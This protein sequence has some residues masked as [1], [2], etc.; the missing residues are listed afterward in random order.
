VSAT[1]VSKREFVDTGLTVAGLRGADF[2]SGDKAG[3]RIAGA[4]AASADGPGVTYVYDGD[5]DWTGHRYGV[6]SPQWRAQVAATDAT[7]EQLREAL[8]PD[9]RLVVVADHGMVDSPAAHRIDVDEHLELRAGV[10]LLGGEARFRHLYCA[11]GA[12]D[13]VLATWREK[14][15]DRALVLSR[16]EAIERGWFGVVASEVR[17]RLGDVVVA[18]RGDHAVVSTADFPYEN[19]LV[20]L[21][22]SLTAVEMEIPILIG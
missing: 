13:D 2:V 22:G 11:G 21:H 5:V 8:D 17:P 6:D 4:V 20:G 18:S 9:V 14:L 1:V 19:R 3:E 12:V 7:A 15:G 16:D 10:R